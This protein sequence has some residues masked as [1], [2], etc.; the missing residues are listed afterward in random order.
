M[1]KIYTFLESIDITPNDISIY[2]QAFTHKTFTNEN[3]REANYEMLE[4][5]G[6]SL[7]NFKSSLYIYKKFKNLN[8]GEASIKRS[9]I[10]DTNSLSSLSFK[11]GLN[12]ILRISKGA[13]EIL[14]NKKINADLYES[15]VAAIFLD[16][17]ENKLEDFLK[18]T[19]YQ[20][21]DESI[22]ELKKDPKSQ[23]QEIVQS[24]YGSRERWGEYKVQK[25]DD[26][27]YAELHFEGK[28]YGKGKGKSKKIAE[29]EAA[30]QA[31]S[32]FKKR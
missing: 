17:T 5:L 26:D 11:L 30:K 10:I 14:N 22:D 21:I 23:F 2:K 31:L 13:L 28:I 8:E 3:K 6:D 12:K 29:T 15:L 18:K 19:L 32:I 20:K 25:I 27:F 9:Q 4:F 1:K 16:Q 7:I 24:L